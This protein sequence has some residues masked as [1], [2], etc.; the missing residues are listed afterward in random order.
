MD[1]KFDYNFKNQIYNPRNS[2]FLM[3]DIN[4]FI[5]EINQKLENKITK[6][7]EIPL[8]EILNLKKEGIH[9]LILLNLWEKPILDFNF[10]D[11]NEE[12]VTQNH[13]PIHNFKIAKN[14]GGN[15][16]F[17]HFVKELKDYN[18]EIG[19]HF[20]FNNISIDSEICI[21]NAN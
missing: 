4:L 16:E 8:S 10:E 20:D 17:L 19:I 13:L 9:T 5:S 14:L 3:K 1:Y 2:T 6:F 12:E 15:D 11:I 18:F 7:S 21:D